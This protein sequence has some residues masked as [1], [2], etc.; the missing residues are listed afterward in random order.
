MLK[1]RSSKDLPHSP[2]SELAVEPLDALF[3]RKKLDLEFDL[4]L[5]Y[6]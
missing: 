2:V 3:E 1:L 6:S 5:D 4:E